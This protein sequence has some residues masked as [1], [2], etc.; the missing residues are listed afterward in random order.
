MS[1]QLIYDFRPHF[2]ASLLPWELV[3]DIFFRVF[4]WEVRDETYRVL[5]SPI[6]NTPSNLMHLIANATR[7]VGYGGKVMYND[8]DCNTYPCSTETFFHCLFMFHPLV[9]TSHLHIRIKGLL[10]RIL[11]DLQTHSREKYLQWVKDQS[12][13]DDST[14]SSTGYI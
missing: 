13:E 9:M 8:C 4:V 12:D 7:F 10:L 14:I 6:T 2:L 3:N 11:R 1:G 5:Q